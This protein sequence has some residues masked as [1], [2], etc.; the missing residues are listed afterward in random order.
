MVVKLRA[1]HV[2]RFIE[3]QDDLGDLV[4]AMAI[5]Q[6]DQETVTYVKNLFSGLYDDREA[7]IEVL[8]DGD[9]RED[10]VCQKC[11]FSFNADCFL[12]YGTSEK[13]RL[14]DAEARKNYRLENKTYSVEDL[15]FRRVGD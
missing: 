3:Y 6:Y 12:E 10:A 1:H 9:A 7:L 14:L 15:L 4:R 11:V 13:G 5:A 8:P 2:A